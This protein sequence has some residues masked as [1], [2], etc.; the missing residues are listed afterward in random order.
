MDSG[1]A[2][3][4]SLHSGRFPPN[5]IS[6]HFLPFEARFLCLS[7]SIVV[8]FRGN[9]GQEL[10]LSVPNWKY[11]MVKN[12]CFFKGHYL[13]LGCKK[14]SSNKSS[15]H[16]VKRSSKMSCQEIM[17]SGVAIPSAT[18]GYFPLI[19]FIIAKGINQGKA[20]ENHSCADHLCKPAFFDRNTL[21]LRQKR[22][23]I[24]SEAILS[25][26]EKNK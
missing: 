7:W 24:G 5:I 10:H 17:E 25:E 16:A 12:L 4:S 19:P 9:C 13:Y 6:P 20:K 2:S 14:G 11:Q 21:L 26:I 22:P 18:F 1:H 3:D 23:M 8:C 15:H